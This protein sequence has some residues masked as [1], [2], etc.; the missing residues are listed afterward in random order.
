MRTFAWLLCGGLA[1]GCGGRPSAWNTDF[2]P[3]D[4]SSGV[5]AAYGLTGSVAVVDKPLSRVTLLRSPSALN[6]SAESFDLGRDLATAQRSFDRQ[7]LFL[8]S[9]GVQP[10]RNPSDEPPK[11]TL[12]DGGITPKIKK[13]YTLNGPLDQLALDPQNEWAVVYGGSG[14]VVNQNELVLID[15]LEK[16]P[17]DAVTFKTLR[18]FGKTPDRLTFTAPLTIPGVDGTRRI[19]IVERDTDIDLLDLSSP[20]NDEVTVPLP[21]ADNGSAGK[22]AQVAYGQDDAVGAIVAVRVTGSSSVFLLQL[23]APAQAGQGFSV[24]TNLVDVGGFPST[25]DFVHTSQG[26][27]LV[28][29]VG[30]NAVLVDP[31]TAITATAVMPAAFTGIRRITNALDP[32]AAATDTDVALLYSSTSTQIAYF[33]LGGAPGA[34]YRSIEASDIG[35]AVQNVIDVPGDTFHDRKIL[36]TPN[37]DFYVLNLTTRQ[38]APMTTTTGLTLEVAPDGQRVWAYQPG[39]PGFAT[40]DFQTLHPVSLIAERNVN[41][42]FDIQAASGA[43]NAIA[44]HFG[45]GYHGG[46]GA[47]VI[48]VSA[49]STATARFFSGF[50]LGG[51]Q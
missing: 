22:S 36:E 33:T 49:P 40:V 31:Q 6:V 9:R 28:A 23:S 39:A 2:A 7:T 18:T 3:A 35:V 4:G 42:V 13:T 17:A 5:A 14:V 8:L 1:L 50:E 47:T 34:L 20:K 48:D 32:T 26:L 51:I 19:L 25:I 10:Q 16:D 24:V 46:V 45:D 27:R 41:S 12:I 11:L 44:L 37:K 30:T 15:L 29:L 21:A 38:S 43:R